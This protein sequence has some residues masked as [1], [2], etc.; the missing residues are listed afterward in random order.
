MIQRQGIHKI[1]N[2]RYEFKND[3]VESFLKGVTSYEELLRWNK[4][5]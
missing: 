2:S 1:A 5:F 3:V 4:K